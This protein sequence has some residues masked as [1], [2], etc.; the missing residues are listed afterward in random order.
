MIGVTFIVVWSDES[1]DDDEFYNDVMKNAMMRKNRLERE[2]YIQVCSML[3]INLL[4]NTFII[5]FKK[6]RH[7]STFFTI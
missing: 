4:S 5:E 7:E 3:M 2:E 1:E 6:S